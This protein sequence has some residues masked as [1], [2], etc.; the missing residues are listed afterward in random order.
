MKT[1]IF[2]QSQQLLQLIASQAGSP[3]LSQNLRQERH[4]PRFFY[5][6]L[7]DTGR[8][9]ESSSDMPITEEQLSRLLHLVEAQPS[10]RG[11]VELNNDRFS[12]LKVAGSDNKG[13]IIAYVNSEHDQET[14]WF[15]LLT[16]SAV[17]LIY[18]VLAYFGGR[19]LAI[20]ALQPIM[21]SWQKQKDF[22]ADASHELRTPLTVIQTNLEL[23][24]GNQ[25]ES[26]ATQMKWLDYINLETQHLTKLVND[27]LLLARADSAEVLLDVQELSLADV[28]ACSIEPLRLMAEQKGVELKISLSEDIQIFGDKNRLKQLL[29]ILLDNALKHTP[30]GGLITVK[31]HKEGNNAEILVT[32]T[33]EGIA[34]EHLSHIFERFYRVDKARS[35]QTGGS[36]LGLPIAQWI[37]QNH[38]GTISVNSQPGQGTEFTIILPVS[39]SRLKTITS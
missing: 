31:L 24:K 39:A 26:V 5:V 11:Q 33:G 21:L 9:T 35:K 14:L 20:R 27:L 19:Y 32:D 3:I 36:G 13:Q 4:V 37:V 38:G 30:Y 15:L 2:N 7:D 29:I 18:M 22:V 1:V 8:I 10:P 17:G 12:F 28:I 6:K 34:I 25:D 16:L 23:V